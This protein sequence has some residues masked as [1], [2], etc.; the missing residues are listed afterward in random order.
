MPPMGAYSQPLRL[1]EISSVSQLTLERENETAA[2]TATEAA[3]AA[4]AG[5]A[6]LG[7][8]VAIWAI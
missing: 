6:R 8:M 4:K 2:L 3:I 5:S 7:A 1:A